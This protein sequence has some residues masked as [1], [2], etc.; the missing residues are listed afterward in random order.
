MSV[1][2]RGAILVVRAQVAVRGVSGRGALGYVLAWVAVLLVSRVSVSMLGIQLAPLGSSPLDTVGVMALILPAAVLTRCLRSRTP[3]LE[4]TRSRPRQPA[5]ALWAIVLAAVAVV[6]PVAVTG[7]LH[8]AFNAPAFHTDW[9]LVA[10][11]CLL[12]GTV[13]SSTASTI[14]AFA[15]VAIF[16]APNVVPWNANVLY[17][18]DLQHLSTPLG[19]SALGC[20][21]VLVGL[22]PGAAST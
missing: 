22:R 5:A 20:A 8:P 16:S 15:V 2:I 18:L 14:T 3:E 1:R 6:S 10:G 17:N 4:C 9:Y 11:L 19:A 12:L 13:M 21:A 7:L